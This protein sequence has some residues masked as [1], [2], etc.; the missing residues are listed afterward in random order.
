VGI[1]DKQNSFFVFVALPCAFF[2]AVTVGSQMPKPPDFIVG[3]KRE[4]QKARQ[5]N[6]L[7]LAGRTGNATCC[8][9]MTEKWR[10]DPLKVM[11]ASMVLNTII[12]MSKSR[13]NDMTQLI[14]QTP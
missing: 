9:N 11:L 1:D 4:T 10:Q 2:L 8:H 3:K 7:P 6:N 5:Q 13:N 14:S 12:E